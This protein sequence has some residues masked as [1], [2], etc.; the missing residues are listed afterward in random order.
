MIRE[1]IHI[2]NKQL[3]GIKPDQSVYGLAQS[4][5]RVQGVEREL[6]PAIIQKDGEASPYV[7]IDDI[8]SLIIYHKLLSSQSAIIN[9]GKGDNP[10]DITNTYSMALFL[11]WDRNRLDIMPDELLMMIQARFPVIITGITDVKTLRVRIGSS[12][13]NSLQVY[14]Q[15]YQESQPKL[16]ANIHLMQINY[17]IE[18][19]FNPACIKACP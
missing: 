12:N 18:L 4:V 15:E 11:Y 1:V 5:L 6:L 2:L 13:M 8:K 14:S 3:E 16:P 19:T 17:T 7:G 10:G 9:N